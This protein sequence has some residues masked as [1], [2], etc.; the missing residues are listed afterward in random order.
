MGFIRTILIGIDAVIYTILEQIFQLIINLANFD[1]FTGDVLKEFSTKI[2]LIL[3]LVM[4]FKLMLSFIQI[5]IDPD[6]INDKE[7]GVVNILKRVVICS[8]Y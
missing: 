6:K 4:V 5:L 3:G 2:Y 8:L 7:T 1:L